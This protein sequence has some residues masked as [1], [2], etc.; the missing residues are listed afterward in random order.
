MVYTKVTAILSV[1]FILA[2]VGPMAPGAVRDAQFWLDAGNNSAHPN[3]WEN[4]GTAGGMVPGGKN[5]GAE[6]PVLEPTAWNGR[7]A[8]TAKAVKQLFAGER[9]DTPSLHLEDWTG[10]LVLKR[11][12]PGWSEQH[13]LFGFL[14]DYEPNPRQMILSVFSGQDAGQVNIYILGNNTPVAQ[15][16]NHTTDVDIGVN[17]WRQIAF[18]YNDEA[19]NIQPYMDGK[20]VGKPISTAQDFDAKPDM[21]IISLFYQRHGPGEPVDRSFNGSI[22]I[23]RVYDRA[24]NDAQI[25]DNYNNPASY[26]VPPEGKLATTWGSLKGR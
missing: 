23:V 9:G 20:P 6:T 26:A 7:P 22:S 2:I 24:L 25:L 14:S 21:S 17:K 8:Y 1:V 10:E 19:N 13:Q 5:I 11:N 4:L 16:K 12:G 3:G 15:R 18:A